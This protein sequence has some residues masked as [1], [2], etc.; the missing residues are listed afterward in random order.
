M[1]LD[2]GGA[3]PPIDSEA[4]NEARSAL[5]APEI[6][7]VVTEA[8]QALADPTR[9]RI[10]YALL[11]RPLCVRDL[12]HL[13]GVSESGVSHQLRLLRDRRLVK[14]RRDGN[15]IYYEVDDHHLPALFKEA[16]YHADHVGRGLPDH[17]YAR[18]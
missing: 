2:V 16:E 10:L 3:P 11:T 14:P 9:V 6:L 8:F 4:L 5:P 15:V 7:A 18:P 1:K 17:P 13:T 12:A